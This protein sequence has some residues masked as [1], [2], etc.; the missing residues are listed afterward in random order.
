MAA[1]EKNAGFSDP[2]VIVPKTTLP[3]WPSSGFEQITN[4]H[5]DVMPP[6]TEEHV[7]EYFVERQL[8]DTLPSSNVKG[9]EL[10]RDLL[11]SKRVQAISVCEKLDSVYFTGMVAAAMK[12][13][14]SYSFKVRISKNGTIMNSD[15]ECPAGKGP[16][17]T[18]KHIACIALLLVEFKTNGNNLSEKTCTEVLQQ[19]HK[20]KQTH[21]GPPPKAEDLKPLLKRKLI[22]PR[23]GPGAQ[24]KHPQY[25]DRVRNMLINF[26]AQSGIHTSYL[27]I[28]TPAKADIQAA[29]EDHWYCK[30]PLTHY[31]VD[32]LCITSQKDAETLEKKTRKQALS[33]LWRDERKIRLTASRFGEICKLTEKKNISKLCD[34]LYG[35]KTFKSE[36]T[37]HGIKHEKIARKKLEEIEGITVQECGLY[38]NPNFPYL[39]ASPDGIIGDD[40][41]VEIKCPYAGREEK[42]QPGTFFPYVKLCNGEIILSETSNY[43]YQIQGEMLLS[44]R[45]KCKFVIF[46]FVDIKIINVDLN[47]DFCNSILIPK[48]SLFYEN[49]YRQYLASKL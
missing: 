5:Q 15:C 14:L 36:A 17:S 34:S 7:Q 41:V 31:T 42:I 43:F 49:H 29:S 47:E 1:Y 27:D 22:D 3:D 11:N 9:L 48:L 21:K 46:T 44:G 37:E 2:V 35:E 4:D 24:I 23:T 6:I 40:T 25:N 32:T 13:R 8:K 18:C 20:P 12:K 26:K 16:S 45:K 30:L 38:V 33:Q 19:F 39:G 28:V 10:G